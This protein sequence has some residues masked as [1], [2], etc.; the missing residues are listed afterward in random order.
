[1][2]ILKYC[3][4]YQLQ[5][6]NSVCWRT[7]NVSLQFPAKLN[8]KGVVRGKEYVPCQTERWDSLKLACAV[9]ECAI[10]WTSYPT[11]NTRRGESTASLQ[12]GPG[13]LQ[14]C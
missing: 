7:D 3:G 2:L 6:E 11:G 13:R 9:W 12:S 1:L 4:V 10:C 5:D 14:D 8:Q